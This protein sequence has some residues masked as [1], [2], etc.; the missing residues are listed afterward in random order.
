MNDVT[1][2]PVPS[3]YWKQQVDAWK[4]S[5]LSQNQFCKSNDLTYH[6][7]VY[8]RS[9]FEAVTRRRHPKEGIGFTVVN[10]LPDSDYGLT[11]TLPN[12]LVVRGICAEKS[13]A[14]ASITGAIVM[15]YYFRP[16]NR[17]TRIYL[18]RDPVDFRKVADGLVAIVEHELVHNPLNY[19]VL[20]VDGYADYNKVCQKNG[21]TRI[22]CCDHCRRNRVEAIKAAGVQKKKGGAG[23]PGKA[24]VAMGMINRLYGLE[25]LFKK[26]DDEQR[27]QAMKNH[28]LPKLAE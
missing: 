1:E 18:Y 28:S 6:R 26:L 15:P 8:W 11:L 23:K 10:C 9:K 3:A 7:F 22:G 5:E 24:D 20:Q 12:G 21:I 16:S 19:G 14:A 25:R 17:M 27:K 13:P 4:L 2:P